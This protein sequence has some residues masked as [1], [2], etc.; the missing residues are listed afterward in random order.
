MPQRGGAPPAS[1]AAAIT[2]SASTHSYLTNRWLADPACR[3]DACARDAYFRWLEDTMDERLVDRAERMAFVSRQQRLLARATSGA[4]SA[5]PSPEEGL[6][7]GLFRPERATPGSGK[8]RA[9]T[10]DGRT[11]GPLLSVRSMLGVMEF[12][13]RRRGRPVTQHELDSYTGELAIAV[14]EASHHCIGH[15]ERSPQDETR[16]VAVTGDHSPQ[17]A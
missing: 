8:I 1:P 12:E 17:A 10:V 16:Y 13:A 14:T 9:E 4:T 6:L 5:G 3:D 7:M 11:G 15:G 2:R